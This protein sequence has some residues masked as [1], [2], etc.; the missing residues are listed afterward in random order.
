VKPNPFV[1]PTNLD[2]L[3]QFI[4][5]DQLLVLQASLPLPELDTHFKFVQGKVVV[6]FWTEYIKTSWIEEVL[7]NSANYYKQTGKLKN[8]YIFLS[9]HKFPQHLIDQYQDFFT[10]IQDSSLYSYYTDKILQ[11]PIS[12]QQKKLIFLLLNNRASPDRQ[13]LYYFVEKFGLRNSSYFSYLGNLDRTRFVSYDQITELIVDSSGP[14]FVKNL[15]TKALNQQIPVTIPG[16][17]FDVNDWTQGQD[18]YYQD[19]FCSVVMETFYSESEVCFSE[20][21]FKPI[22]FGHPFIL[23]CSVGSLAQLQQMGFQTF[24]NFWDEDYD[25]YSGTQR[26]E[27]IFHLMLEIN[28]WSQTRIDSVYNSMMPVLQHNQEHFFKILPQQFANTKPQL[29]DTIKQL[30]ENKKGLL[31]AV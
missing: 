24:G 21:T 7:C 23:N 12:T 17:Q 5:S 20:K 22:A 28:N 3:A 25:Q 11:Q 27:C 18:H 19:T 30:F 8:Y 16:D 2:G 15:N 26:L 9:V 14:W 10:V 1:P 13:S 4:N 29:F 31:N 6:L